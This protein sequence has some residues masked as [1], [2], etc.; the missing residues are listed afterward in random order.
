MKHL[1]LLLLPLGAFA[2]QDF[3]YAIYTRHEKNSLLMAG[4]SLVILSVERRI[5]KEGSHLEIIPC[6][7]TGEAQ[8]YKIEFQ[9][10]HFAP[11]SDSLQTIF[12]GTEMMSLVYLSGDQK[13]RINIWPMIP[14][15]EIHDSRT[16]I[17]YD[18]YY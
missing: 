12:G 16:G 7:N 17:L 3:D 18:R 11:L 10:F 8:D 14:L 15:L 4:D 1:L 13:Y 5:V 9:G 2:Q 6:S